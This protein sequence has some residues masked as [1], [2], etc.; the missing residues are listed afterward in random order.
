MQFK[1][2][3]ATSMAATR[4]AWCE[5]SES[6][7]AFLPDVEQQLDW[8]ESHV[9]LTDNEIACGIFKDDHTQVAS[10]ICEL[11]VTRKSS[12]A[13]WIK[14]IRLRLRPTIDSQIFNNDPAG[15][16]AAIQA[17]IAC[18]LGVFHMKNE[19]KANTIKVYGRTQQQ[20]QFLAGLS[21]GLNKMDGIT[22]KASIEG[23]WLVLTW[24]T[25]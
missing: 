17:Y 13:K 21:A 22:F 24:K 1:Q 20:M 4:R 12:R 2:F 9:Q 16:T 15:L 8:A 7:G 5:D 18:V 11:I 10:A 23:R 6:T 3:D 14:F 19:H 25:S